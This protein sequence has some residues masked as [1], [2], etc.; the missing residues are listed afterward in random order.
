L[1]RSV[2]EVYFDDCGGYIGNGSGTIVLDGS[3]VLTNAHVVAD[4]YGNFCDLWI[5]AADSASETP[6]WIANGRVIPAAYDPNVDLA[7]IRLVDLGGVPTFAVGRDPIN[8]KNIEIGLGDEIKVLGYPSM[9]GNKI[10][11]T[12]GEHSGWWEGS[13]GEFYKTSAKAGPGVS[14]GAAFNANTG[15]FVGVPTA[16]TIVDSGDTLGL[17]RPNSY[18]FQYLQIAKNAG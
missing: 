11:M 1:A 14:G 3:Y 4:D 16:G 7:V 9:G 17:I 5:Y 13:G 8:I 2:V 6:H 10:T 15:E 12:S 18:I